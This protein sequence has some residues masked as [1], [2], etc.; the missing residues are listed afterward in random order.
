MLVL[1]LFMLVRYWLD[2]VHQMSAHHTKYVRWSQLAMQGKHLCGIL[3][4]ENHLCSK[5][6]TFHS[7]A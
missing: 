1:A 3:I 6:A 4:R 2:L 7:Q 5:F